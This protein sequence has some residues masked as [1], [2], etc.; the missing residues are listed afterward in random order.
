M[1]SRNVL[2][3]APTQFSRYLQSA[4]SSDRPDKFGS[5]DEDDDDDDD[6]WGGE[7]DG[8]AFG[9]SSKNSSAPGQ[10]SQSFGFDDRFDSMGT[11]HFRSALA[12]EQDA[13]EVSDE[14]N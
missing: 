2:T 3:N 14:V 12:A 8:G 6:V 9:L 4:I 13:E 7:T 11:Q 1:W 5:S 10:S